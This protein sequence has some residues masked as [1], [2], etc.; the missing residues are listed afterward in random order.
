MIL[1]VDQDGGDEKE[2]SA[3]NNRAQAGLC[4]IWLENNGVT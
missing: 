2:V 4:E 3:A 1:P